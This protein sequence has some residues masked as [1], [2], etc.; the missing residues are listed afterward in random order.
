M[1]LSCTNICKFVAILYTFA[2]QHET[3]RAILK[4][5]N[6]S[7]TNPRRI[8]FD[9]LLSQKPVTMR[10]LTRLASGKLDRA[11]VYRT[12]KLYEKLGVVHRLNVGWKYKVELSDAFLGHHHHFYCSNCGRTFSMEPN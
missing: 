6:A 5:N 10:A 1:I 12:I 8:V 2:M 3:L 9:L 11:T 4:R 7:L